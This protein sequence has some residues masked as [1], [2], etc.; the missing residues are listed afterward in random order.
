MK[1]FWPTQQAIETDPGMANAVNNSPK[2]VFSKTLKKVEEGP[3]WKNIKLL[4]EIKK[5]EIQKLKKE[6][7]RTILGGQ[8]YTAASEPGSIDEY[9][10]IVPLMGT[11]RSLFENVKNEPQTHQCKFQMNC[12]D[13][14][15]LMEKRSDLKAKTAN[16]NVH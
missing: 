12:F 8:Y 11:G 5:D 6:G 10:V 1:S 14:T 7:D 15:K 4:H 3:N 9:F 16:A 13:T 2:I